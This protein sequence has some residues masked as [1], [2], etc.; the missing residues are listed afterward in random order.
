MALRISVDLDGL[1]WADLFRFV[2]LARNG[3][4]GPDDQ[5]DVIT[6]GSDPMSVSL[7]ARIFPQSDGFLSGEQESGAEALRSA[8]L[9]IN[10]APS[11]NGSSP[12]GYDAAADRAQSPNGAHYPSFDGAPE[13][14]STPPSN[15]P[16][17]EAPSDRGAPGGQGGSHYP[18]FDNG[19]PERMA[20][21][22]QYA[23]FEPVFDR[24]APGKELPGSNPADSPY[25]EEFARLQEGLMR[26]VRRNDEVRPERA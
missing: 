24:G 11:S 18:S 23:G 14:P 17:Y 3:G 22:G 25:I 9:S 20:G 2:D 5:V 16:A 7:S 26:Q 15:Y 10:P 4:I 12:Y 8:P 6:Y 1:R 19:Q 21:G 13:R